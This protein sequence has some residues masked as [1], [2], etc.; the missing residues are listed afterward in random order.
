MPKVYVCGFLFSPDRSLVLLIR[1]HRPAW[2]AGKLNGI[3]GKIEPGETPRQAMAREFAEEAGVPIDG[4]REGVILEGSPTAFDPDG[5]RG[6]FFAA[7]A[8]PE[9]WAAVKTVTDECVER[10]P[11]RALPEEVI[12]NLRWIIPLLLDDEHAIARAYAV[13]VISSEPAGAEAVS[14]PAGPTS[15]RDPSR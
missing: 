15:A 9:E 5:W 3:G 2:Q 7:F 13:R 11:V 1:K 10:H 12:P 4:W 6:H 8:T 14:P